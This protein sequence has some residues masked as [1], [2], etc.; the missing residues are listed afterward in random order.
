MA[1]HIIMKDEKVIEIINNII[2]KNEDREA[3]RKWDRK[4]Q[5]RINKSYLENYDIYITDEDFE[6]AEVFM[7]SLREE[8][9]DISKSDYDYLK[10]ELQDENWFTF[11]VFVFPT[12]RVVWWVI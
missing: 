7:I 4:V 9:G 5:E 1:Q 12:L 8:R 11:E 6:K 3:C 10:K 2:D